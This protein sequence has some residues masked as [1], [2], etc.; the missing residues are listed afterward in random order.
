M[1]SRLGTLAVNKCCIK[2]ADCRYP[3][4]CY[5][6]AVGGVPDLLYL[7]ICHFTEK[8]L[9]FS[10]VYLFTTF[11]LVLKCMSTSCQML[12]TFLLSVYRLGYSFV[13][14]YYLLVLNSC[15]YLFFSLNL[16]VLFISPITFQLC[17]K[18]K[19]VMLY[20]RYIDLY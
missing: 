12:S 6:F 9:L 20:S 4:C 5:F 19:Q 13:S 3:F 14:T 18:N 11:K 8:C 10:V 16:L 15:D 2:V 1:N 7:C 17:C